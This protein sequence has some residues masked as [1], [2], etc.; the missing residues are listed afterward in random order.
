MEVMCCCLG[1]GRFLCPQ[2]PHCT[3]LDRGLGSWGRGG[4]MSGCA[5]WGAGF[6]FWQGS[7][8]RLMPSLLS[9]F[10]SLFV[11]NE[12]ECGDAIPGLGGDGHPH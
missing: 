7:G 4:C 10:P 1:G 12:E 3:A 2:L 5:P 11:L 6:W 8:E 9:P